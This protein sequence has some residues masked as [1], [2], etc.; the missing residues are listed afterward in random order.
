MGTKRIAA[1]ALTLAIAFPAAACHSDSAPVAAPAFATAPA[2]SASAEAR[3]PVPYAPGLGLPSPEFSSRQ[4][5]AVGVRALALGRSA[6]RPLRTLIFYPAV[7]AAPGPG[8]PGGSAAP[9]GTA[10]DKTGTGRA[11][12]GGCGPRG[13]EVVEGADPAVGRFPLVLFSHGLRGSPERYSAAVASWAAAG[14][15]VA[16]PIYPHTNENAAHFDRADIA[17][18]PGD[19][20]Y[21]IKRVRRIDRSAGDP[22]AGHIDVDRVAAVGHSAG[23]YTTTGLFAAKHP[24]W[25]RAGVVIAGWLAPGAF[26]GP[27]A[28]ILFLQGERDT[29]VPLAR[30]RAAYD[31]VPWAK[32]YVL[33]PDGWHADYMAPGGRDY[34]LMDA[35]VIDFLR[36]TLDGDEA[37]RLRLPP[38][39]LP[40][41]PHK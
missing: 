23:G 15:V 14:F 7:S 33:L 4:D 12:A 19:A 29:V 34:P 26:A 31:A 25:L 20:A 37:A 9:S 16:A 17:N 41:G 35:T 28:T 3:V 22:L 39:G 36:W 5:C 32:S 2:G 8:A 38:S 1:I 10:S 27:P 13:V 18:Q 11:V 6:D 24:T 40:A 21:V 30:G